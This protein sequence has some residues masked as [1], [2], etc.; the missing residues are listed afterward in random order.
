MAKAEPCSVP[1]VPRS[2]PRTAPGESHAA[3][4]P[5]C[6]ARGKR[7][8]FRRAALKEPFGPA[9][10]L[11]PTIQWLW[12]AESLAEPPCQVQDSGLPLGRRWSISRGRSLALRARS[13]H[14]HL[15]LPCS[16][17]QGTLHPTLGS[18]QPDPEPQ[19]TEPWHSHGP[20]AA[21]QPPPPD[22]Q[23]HIRRL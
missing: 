6:N 16:R 3:V 8:K 7:Q 4:L 10:L 19:D 18:E 5:A 20:S 14:R 21:A 13:T 11:G 15:A 17:Q 12:W 1:A 9:L 23:R 22:P 2:H